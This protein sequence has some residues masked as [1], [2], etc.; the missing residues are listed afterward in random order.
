MKQIYHALR[1][2]VIYNMSRTDKVSRHGHQVIVQLRSANDERRQV[3]SHI[4]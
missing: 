3:T 2:V 1:L 4:R